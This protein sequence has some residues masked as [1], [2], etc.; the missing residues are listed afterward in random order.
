MIIKTHMV[1]Q[2]SHGRQ[3]AKCATAKSICYFDN[4]ICHQLLTRV[5]PCGSQL[6]AIQCTWSSYKNNWTESAA[7][8][9]SLLRHQ[10]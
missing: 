7:R 2:K 6:W 10:I 9:G 5:V 8:A 3:L 4:C 1:A